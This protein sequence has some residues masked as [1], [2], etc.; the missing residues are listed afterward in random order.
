MFKF[1]Y[2]LNDSYQRYNL[3]ITTTKN[4]YN[5]GFTL[6]AFNSQLMP[7]S[8]IF[9]RLRNSRIKNRVC[10]IQFIS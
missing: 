2:F 6:L 1:L 7:I 4:W 10:F 9:T 5:L 8:F 3:G